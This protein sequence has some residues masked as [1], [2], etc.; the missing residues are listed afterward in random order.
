MFWAIVGALLFVFVGIPILLNLMAIKEFWYLIL[1]VVVVLGVIIAIIVSSDNESEPSKTYRSQNLSN[2]QA[3]SNSPIGYTYSNKN[4]FVAPVKN[5]NEKCVE[6]SFIKICDLKFSSTNVNASQYREVMME[7][8]NDAACVDMATGGVIKNTP[9]NI[10]ASGNMSFCASDYGYVYIDPALKVSKFYG[11]ITRENNESPY[12]ISSQYDT[13]L[14]TYQ[15]GNHAVPYLE[16]LSNIGPR[17]DNIYSAAAFCKKG[18]SQVD[19]YTEP[20]IN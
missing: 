8:T 13:C 7:G 14:W 2:Y 6:E 19:I 4:N 18:N 1:G 5:I 10:R 9:I 17:G 11:K 15:G 12:K 3:S 20:V 16:V